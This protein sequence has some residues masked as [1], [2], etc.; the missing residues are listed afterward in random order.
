[1]SEESS[2]PVIDLEFERGPVNSTLLHQQL[3]TSLGDYFTGISGDGKQIRVHVY[4]DT[5]QALQAQIASVV[6]A[7]DPNAK[8][9]DQQ[10][11]D[12]RETR[13]NALRKTWTSWTA[14]DREAFIRILAEQ[15]GIVLE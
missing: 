4:S 1:M 8:T 15:A 2:K 7:H 6:S 10:R 9:P 12:D 5:P 14:L 3:K 13:T 11:K